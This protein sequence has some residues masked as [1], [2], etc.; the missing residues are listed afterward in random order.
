MAAPAS[1]G[2]AQHLP[3]EEVEAAANRLNL[4]FAAVGP[5]IA[6]ELREAVNVDRTALGRRPYVLPAFL[7]VP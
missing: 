1:P 5:S 7:P 3:P 2:G 6:A 4:H